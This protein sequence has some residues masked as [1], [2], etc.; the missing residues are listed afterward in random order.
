MAINLIVKGITSKVAGAGLENL[1]YS[2]VTEVIPLLGQGFN[3]KGEV[4]FIESLS[5]LSALVVVGSP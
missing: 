2:P 5:H 4:W 3:D 1:V